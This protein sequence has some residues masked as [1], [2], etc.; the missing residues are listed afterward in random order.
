MS[1]A[2]IVPFSGAP[3]S[4]PSGPN[5]AFLELLARG[6][7]NQILSTTA[8][9]LILLDLDPELIGLLSYDELYC[10][11]VINR[12]PPTAHTGIRARPGP[13]PRPWDDADIQL[14]LSYMQRAWTSGFKQSV[15]EGAM[16]ATADAHRFH[17]IRDWLAA[18]QW[19]GTP[20][21]DRWLQAAFDSPNN[22]YTS[23]VGAR[24]LIAAVRRV[25]QPGCKFDHM[26]IFE[27]AQGIG[28][29]TALRALFG[30]A[31]FT[32]SLPA[33]VGSRD[34]A[35]ALL[36]VWGVELAEIDQVIRAEVETVKA[37]LSRPVDRYRPPYG[38]SFVDAPRQCVLVGTSNS[39]D[40]LR[41]TSGNRR[42]WPIECRAADAEW[43]TLNREQLWAEAAQ[44]ESQGDVLWLQEHEL[45][46]TAV[47]V[48][49]S[50]LTEDTWQDALEDW[51]Y[52]RVET[53]TADALLNGIGVQREKQDRRATLRVCEC[54]RK[55]GWKQTVAGRV[56]NGRRVWRK[57]VLE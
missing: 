25:R 52:S 2:N 30:D 24:F 7:K 1:M 40:Y 19:D 29:S 5:L 41:D 37:F 22:P 55:L 31:W 14:L 45:N 46:A 56:G 27:G 28:K 49:T 43:V 39:S 44:R 53:T 48:Q 3:P 21:I 4:G 50:R 15:I 34:A 18:L 6:D 16:L 23:A 32:D 51:L 10:R 17:P 20:R 57:D 11:G 47:E 35:L 33:D 36:G 26:P 38:R 8:N 12:S 9:A 54:L 42:F 13:Y